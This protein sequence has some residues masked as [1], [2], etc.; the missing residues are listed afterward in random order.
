MRRRRH[1]FWSLNERS[2]R[3]HSVWPSGTPQ[4][5]LCGSVAVAPDTLSFES[6]AVGTTSAAKTI[7]LTAETATV[8][9]INVEIFGPTSADFSFQT[10][11]STL[12]VAA[13][14]SINVTFTPSQTGQRAGLLIINDSAGG[15]P[16]TVLLRGIAS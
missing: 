1:Q 3:N 14:C 6:Q 2:Q 16:Q 11:C 9:G 8:S 15:T 7:T 10:G 13:K 4:P 5:R 12:A